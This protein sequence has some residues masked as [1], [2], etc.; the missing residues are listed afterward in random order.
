MDRHTSSRNQRSCVTTR[1]APWPLGQRVLRWLASQLM[2]RTSRWLVGSSSMSTS[3]SPMSSRARSTRRRWPP[4]SSPIRASQG[5]SSMSAWM[6]SR[7]RGL[8][9]HSWVGTSPHHLAAHRCGVVQRVALPQKAHRQRT[10]RGDLAIVRLE[11]P[12]RAGAA[13]WTCRRR[14]DPPRRCGHPRPRPTSPSRTPCAWGTPGRGSRSLQGSP[15]VAHDLSCRINALSQS[16]R[17]RRQGTCSQETS[18]SRI[19]RSADSSRSDN[20]PIFPTVPM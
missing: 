18:C 2:A 11:L 6:I 10:A 16:H 17:M 7:V 13:A 1:S 3:Q 9:A 5:M 12:P 20:L 15:L 4:D 14:C 8:A 19:P